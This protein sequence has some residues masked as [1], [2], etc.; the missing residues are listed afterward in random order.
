MIALP[1]FGLLAGFA[2]GRLWAIGVTALAGA[3]GFGLVAVLTD[4]VSGWGDVFV[5]SVTAA[6]LVATRLGV[7]LRTRLR[8][9]AT[10]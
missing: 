9:R 10:A 6:A 8:P 4:E 5:W 3:L 1:I 2:I 7:L